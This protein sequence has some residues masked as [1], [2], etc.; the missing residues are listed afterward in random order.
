MRFYG[1]S[2]AKVRRNP[3]MD[4]NMLQILVLFNSLLFPEAGGDILEVACVG[5]AVEALVSSVFL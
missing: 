1:L 2:G 5:A 3:K 4:S